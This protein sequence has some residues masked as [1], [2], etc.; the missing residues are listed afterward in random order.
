[1]RFFPCIMEAFVWHL[2]M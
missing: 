2:C 1:M